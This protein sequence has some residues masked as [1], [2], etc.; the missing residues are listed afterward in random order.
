MTKKVKIIICTEKGRIEKYSLLL[1]R[2]LRKFGGDFSDVDIYSFAPRKG[3]EPSRKT[4]NEFK[5]LNVIHQNIVLNTKYRSY[6]LANKPLVC[7]YF[8]EKFPNENV[9]FIDSDQII[10]N[11][12]DE[13][14]LTENADTRLRSVDRKGVGFSTYSDKEFK[15][16]EVL[17]KLLGLDYSLY[18]KIETSIGQSIY[19]YYN[20]GL[21]VTK[22]SFGLFKKWK[23]NFEQIYNLK[24]L[25]KGNDFFV[26]QSVF[27]ATVLQMN[28]SIQHFDNKYNYPYSLHLE[29]DQKLQVD[30]FSNLVSIHYHDMF[31]M[32]KD[33][34]YYEEFK[35][36]SMKGK[37]IAQQINDLGIKPS[38]KSELLI[39]K[40][41]RKLL[42]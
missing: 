4:L 22:T 19:P 12:P 29:V 38:S 18:E 17:S 24:L 9:V 42:K 11:Q 28:L 33:F 31:V 16:W 15:Y 37:W 30:D 2:S 27:T 39:Q 7:A 14:I 36:N 20:S 40:I 26:E 3:F 6:P 35:L 13:F 32:K 41:R 1:C 8:E 10:L 34:P 21:I 23:E 5:E 25:T